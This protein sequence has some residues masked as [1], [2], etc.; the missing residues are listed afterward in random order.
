L[1][2]ESDLERTEPP[3]SRRLEKAREDGQVPQSREL[4]AFLIMAAAVGGFWSLGGWLTHQA[5]GILRRGLSFGRD[6][7]FS[8]AP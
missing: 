3:S 2:E 7:A 8:S 5:G 1:A 4:M 6:A